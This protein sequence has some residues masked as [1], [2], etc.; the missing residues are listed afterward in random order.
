MV[1]FFNSHTMTDKIDRILFIEKHYR[2]IIN[3]DF[4][5]TSLILA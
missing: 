1:N 4:V 5:R 2:D 3:L